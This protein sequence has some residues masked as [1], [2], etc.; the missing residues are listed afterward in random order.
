MYA[1]NRKACFVGV[2]I[3]TTL[4]LLASD[5]QQ[6]ATPQQNK[7]KYTLDVNF[8]REKILK[9]PRYQ[10]THTVLNFLNFSSNP[11]FKPLAVYEYASGIVDG[12]NPESKDREPFAAGG[13]HPESRTARW[14]NFCDKKLKVVRT[15]RAKQEDRE[16]FV[17]LCGNPLAA[18]VL[19]FDQTEYYAQFLATVAQAKE[20]YLSSGDKI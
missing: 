8:V 17:L 12:E 3:I 14:C 13:H 4:P 5:P 7:I 10:D 18:E 2:V 9:T 20:Q 16:D 15:N 6:D 11:G 19:R 1:M